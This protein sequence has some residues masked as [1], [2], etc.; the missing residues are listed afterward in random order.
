MKTAS[1]GDLDWKRAGLLAAFIAVGI[2]LSDTPVLWPL[3]L[4]VVMMHETGHALA[5]LIV[6]GSVDEVVISTNE[7]GHCLSM[8]PEGFFGQLI[9]YSG[10]Y[11]GSAVAGGGLMLATFRFRL[12]RPV[13]VAASIWLVVMA[14]IYAGSPFTFVFCA[15]TAV[16]LSVC[17]KYLPDNGV[18]LLNL[19]IAAFSG[20]YV[21][22]D[23]RSDLWNREVRAVSDAALLAQLTFIPSVVWALLWTLMSLAILGASAWWSLRRGAAERISAAAASGNR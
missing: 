9:V 2:V 19:F 13:L 20:L 15:L 6:G 23:L 16:V 17:A 7:S 14:I 22:F 4:L 8:V 21:V 1:G 11:V 18:E 3:K 12:R 10:G 5:A